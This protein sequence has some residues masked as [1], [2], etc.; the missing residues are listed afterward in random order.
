MSSKV[1]SFRA[2]FGT[3]ENHV[4]FQLDRSYTICR[5]HKQQSVEEPACGSLRF[6]FLGTQ[7]F[8]PDALMENSFLCYREVPAPDQDHVVELRSIKLSAS[9]STV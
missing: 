8:S 2:H 6:R 9:A 7:G 1:I 5:K 3:D 4:R